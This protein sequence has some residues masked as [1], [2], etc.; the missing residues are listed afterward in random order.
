MGCD[1]ERPLW[2]GPLLL[3]DDYQVKLLHEY[4]DRAIQ[5]GE[6]V[7][8]N[9]FVR[10]IYKWFMS[11][12]L[13][14]IER[15][16]ELCQWMD[17]LRIQGHGKL[18]PNKGYVALIMLTHRAGY[19]AGALRAYEMLQ[20]NKQV[21]PWVYGYMIDLHMRDG[22]EAMAASYYSTLVQATAG[23]QTTT[24]SIDNIIPS[25][26]TRLYGLRFGQRD[27]VATAFE[28]LDHGEL[29]LDKEGSSAGEAD[30]RLKAATYLHEMAFL[31]VCNHGDLHSAD[32]LV[33]RM[34]DKGMLRGQD[35]SAAQKECRHRLSLQTKKL[36]S[37][38]AAL[39]LQARI[40]PE[41]GVPLADA[42]GW[43]VGGFGD[44]LALKQLCDIV[45]RLRAAAKAEA[46]Q[47]DDDRQTRTRAPPAWTRSLCDDLLLGCI[48]TP[49]QGLHSLHKTLTGEEHIA[50]RKAKGKS[51]MCLLSGLIE[52]GTKG[53]AAI[54]RA[55]VTAGVIAASD[56]NSE[57]LLAQPHLL[58]DMDSYA[59]CV[60][61]LFA[62]G[63]SAQ[64]REIYHFA[65]NE[66]LLI[67]N[68]AVFKAMIFGS[69]HVDNF[70]D[71][72]MYL[73]SME[74]HGH[75]PHEKLISRVL[76]RM[77]DVEAVAHAFEVIDK[78]SY[79]WFEM[80][81]K[82]SG[83]SISDNPGL[84]KKI[85]R[86]FYMALMHATAEYGS[87]ESTTQ[88][89]D[90]MMDARDPL[91]GGRHHHISAETCVCLLKPC[92]VHGATKEEAYA[93]LVPLEL[94]GKLPQGMPIWRSL[95]AECYCRGARFHRLSNVKGLNF[96]VDWVK[97]VFETLQ[98]SCG[99]TDDVVTGPAISAWWG[100]CTQDQSREHEKRGTLLQHYCCN[101]KL[102]LSALLVAQ[103]IVYR[104]ADVLSREEKE[105][106]ESEL[107]ES[108]LKV[109]A[110]SGCDSGSFLISCFSKLKLLQLADKSQ[111]K[112]VAMCMT[113]LKS[114]VGLRPTEEHAVLIR[115]SANNFSPDVL[116]ALICAFNAYNTPEQRQQLA[117]FAETYQPQEKLQT[118][119]RFMKNNDIANILPTTTMLSQ[120]VELFVQGNFQPFISFIDGDV[121]LQCKAVKELILAGHHAQAA[122]LIVRYHLDDATLDIASV[123][124]LLFRSCLGRA[125]QEEEGKLRL[126]QADK[127]AAVD[128]ELCLELHPAVEVAFVG[129]EQ[130]LL[131]AISKFHVQ[132][133]PVRDPYELPGGGRGSSARS[134][135][136][137]PIGLDVEWQPNLS[138]KKTGLRKL[139]V[140]SS[141]AGAGGSKSRSSES[142]PASTLQVATPAF[143]AVFDLFALHAS[144]LFNTFIGWL[145]ASGEVIKVG[146]GLQHD[147]LRIVE[148]YP[149]APGFHA[150]RNYV[151]IQRA[152]TELQGQALSKFCCKFLG[153]PLS[154]RMQ[155]SDWEVRPLTPQ[156]LHYGA[157][158]AHVLLALF[159]ATCSRGDVHAACHDEGGG[160]PFMRAAFGE[161][162]GGEGG[163]AAVVCGVGGG[164][165]V[166]VNGGAAAA[167]PSAEAEAG[168]E[169]ARGTSAGAGAAA[170]GCGVMATLMG[171]GAG[172]GAAGACAGASTA[173]VAVAAEDEEQLLF[174]WGALHCVGKGQV[175]VEGEG[176]APQLPGEEQYNV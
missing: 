168:P 20:A 23:I 147:L 52:L 45:S 85:E 37:S 54:E 31:A 132:G 169:A 122:P 74:S 146:F 175:E 19:K 94:S 144:L 27:D 25:F 17:F 154:K 1:D 140:H 172:A 107:K 118:V 109:P 29:W 88:V 127:E 157:L 82:Y 12:E 18:D 116:T 166:A 51:V 139:H 56:D 110:L 156:Q 62:L 160:Y 78:F 99:A 47:V 66:E 171:A 176:R 149:A 86:N 120:C 108:F 164:A 28:V 170:G 112:F 89:Y 158:D 101:V 90:R 105:K 38:V 129:N 121:G 133:Y 92:A 152:P 123:D 61:S 113:C 137:L 124:L 59:A 13:D 155:T 53:S 22:D 142:R 32:K 60:E 7:S 104:L 6:P 26:A 65:V 16:F 77:G 55:A 71:A 136:R 96:R 67:P 35:E 14:S 42:K 167:A 36:H 11:S 103:C 100:S 106:L 79:E 68:P 48:K 58:P 162:E 130:Q 161:G 97:S 8:G 49:G 73:A 126:A 173:A 174:L 114:S 43:E 33:T 148:S 119:I 50:A 46:E 145:F 9:K 134:G 131:A 111:P 34:I 138:K 128:V 24:T 64:A 81:G 93:H 95:L 163:K 87:V 153:L 2:E 115:G 10:G 70:A 135:L 84:W 159:A 57:A 40:A 125:L 15:C 83:L 5:A 80:Y 44:K 102:P 21:Q 117:A 151:D 143:V 3:P 76:G 98:I 75:A 41:R 69:I 4:V 150:M 63:Q 39:A 141:G 91:T 30:A 165:A 72:A